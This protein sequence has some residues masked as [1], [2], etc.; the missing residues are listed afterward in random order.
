MSCHHLKWRRR[1]IPT[2]AK[3]ISEV[4]GGGVPRRVVDKDVKV[5][6]LEKQDGVN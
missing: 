1:T 6:Q 3:G 4:K 5:A 2:Q